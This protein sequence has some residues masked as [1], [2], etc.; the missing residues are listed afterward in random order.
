[1]STKVLKVTQ[2]V[3]KIA[4]SAIVTTLEKIELE[5]ESLIKQRAI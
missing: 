1:M 5:I 3:Y 4:I 2:P